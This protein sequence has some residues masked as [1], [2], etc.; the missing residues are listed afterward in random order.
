MSWRGRER[1]EK[2]SEEGLYG[3]AEERAPGGDAGVLRWLGNILLPY[4]ERPPLDGVLAQRVARAPWFLIIWQPLPPEIPGPLTAAPYC[5]YLSSVIF[6]EIDEAGRYRIDGAGGAF[7]EHARIEHAL[8]GEDIF[9]YLGAAAD[10]AGV[11]RFVGGGGSVCWKARGDEPARWWMR[12][13]ARRIHPEDAMT[14]A[15]AAE[16]QRCRIG[17]VA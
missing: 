16:A 1:E 17:V 2:L 12:H 6:Y 13:I 14:I 4:R 9:E 10:R 11:E 15:R 7:R 8:Y 3:F 5:C